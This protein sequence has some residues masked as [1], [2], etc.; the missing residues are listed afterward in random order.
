MSQMNIAIAMLNAGY[1]P[2]EMLKTALFETV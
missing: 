1:W 2:T